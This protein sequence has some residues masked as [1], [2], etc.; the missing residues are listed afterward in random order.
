MT[1]KDKIEIGVFFAA[2]AVALVGTMGFL[3]KRG[4]IYG[5]IRR[6][7]GSA[8]KTSTDFRKQL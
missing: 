3:W 8:S 6:G 4:D 7:D 5:P 1:I 2:C